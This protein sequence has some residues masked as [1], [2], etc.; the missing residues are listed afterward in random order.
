MTTQRFSR[1]VGTGSAL[2]ERV[3]DNDQLSRELAERGI[4]T[5][6]EWIV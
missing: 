4:E 3:V 6:K 2:P 1:I 5:S